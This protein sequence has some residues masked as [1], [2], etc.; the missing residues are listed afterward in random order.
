MFR[1][2]LLLLALGT[3][4]LSAHDIAS[5][6]TPLIISGKAEFM[7]GEADTASK[8]QTSR[9]ELLER[10]GLR[11]GEMLES[12]PGLVVTQHSGD[13]KANQFFVRGYNLDHGTDFGVFVDGMPV[14]NRAHAHGQGY[15]DINFII[16]EFVQQL[17]Y[18]KGPFFAERGDMTTAGA[19]E[20]TLVNELQHGFAGVTFGEDNYWRGVF[21]DS[22]EAWGGVLTFGGEATYYEGPWALD[23]DA[24]RFN[25]IVR[26]HRGDE[27]NFFNVTFLGSQGEWRATDQI[28]LRAVAG[29][30]IDR[31][32]YIDPTDGGES[33]R[34]SLSTT[35]GIRNQ[36]TVIRGKAWAGYYDLDLFSN[37]TYFLDDPVN[38]DQFHQADARGFAGADFAVD[39][40][41]RQIFNAGTTYTFGFQTQNDWISD[42]GLSHTVAR[43]ELSTVREDDVFIGS[44]SLYADAKTTWTEWFRTEAGVRGDLF[45][46]DVDSD[47]PANSGGEVDAMIVPKLNLIFSPGDHHEYYL[48][49]GGGFHSNDP[50]GANLKIDPN[51][52]APAQAVDSLVRTWGAELGTRSQWTQC[53]TT[54]VAVWSLFNDSELI[55]VGDAG[56]VEAGPATTRYGIEFAGYYRPNNWLGVDAEISLAEGRYNDIWSTGGPWVENQVP[57]VISSGITLGAG[58]GFFGSLRGR[59]FCERPLTATKGVQ[60]SESFMVNARAGYRTE[61]WELALDCLNLLDRADNDIEYYYTS[62]LPSEP[63]GGVDDIHFHPAE[64]R[65][66]RASFTWFW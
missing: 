13:G 52:G 37:F 47:L 11:K 21:G 43:N 31:F 15:T 27:D 45:V 17:D 3:A 7:L 8:G 61:N 16:P 6:L 51:T 32:G 30:Q 46:S 53:F 49:L 24:S 50:R 34:Y 66:L 62:R 5:E 9:E 14:N 4:C 33:Q 35:F 23:E 19:A 48:N 42:L 58:T 1:C 39:L 10:P 29:G 26:W 18:Q 64:P 60:G 57:V 55:Y 20:F 22:V 65:T 44:Y 59:Y 56:N 36:D 28:P 38:G 12:V 2:S 41:N 54:T 40:E 63:A 25:G